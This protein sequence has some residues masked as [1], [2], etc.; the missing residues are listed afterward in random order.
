ML[1]GALV[2]LSGTTLT[3]QEGRFGF[4]GGN[5]GGNFNGNNG[6]PRAPQ[7]G[8]PRPRPTPGP[9]VQVDASGAKVYEDTTF[10][11]LTGRPSSGTLQQTVVAS[12]VDK[13]PANARITIWDTLNGTTATATVIV[14][15]QARG[16]NGAPQG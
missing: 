13:I 9:S 14:F 6:T 16:G 7:N 5:P 4:G 12:S 15:A 11:N 10:A 2:S 8:T 3:V 1:R